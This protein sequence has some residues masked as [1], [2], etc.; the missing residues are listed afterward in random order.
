MADLY[1][2]F[3]FLQWRPFSSMQTFRT[4]LLDPIKTNPDKAYKKLHGVLQGVLLRRT[5]HSTLEGQPILQLPKCEQTLEK[6][7]FTEKERAFY[8]KLRTESKG[9]LQE[10]KAHAGCAHQRLCGLS[11]FIWDAA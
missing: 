10:L 8:D 3:R 1:S 2:Y 6:I 7:D 11:C 4:H 5:K 9:V